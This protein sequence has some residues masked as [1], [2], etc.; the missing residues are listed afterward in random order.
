M[1]SSAGPGLHVLHLVGERYAATWS[2]AAAAHPAWHVIGFEHEMRFFYAACDLV[3]SRSGGMVAELL[4]TATPSVLI[5]GGFGSKGH[6]AAN[7]DRVVSAGA[8][9]KLP[10]TELERLT[11][12]V[13]AVLQDPPRLAAMEQAA[14]RAGRPDAAATI[15]ERMRVA[16]G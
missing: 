9:V 3:V 6:Q 1:S 4:A 10:E 15:A 2:D 12:T 5:P 13:H 8:A 14:R 11:A 7:A 16:H